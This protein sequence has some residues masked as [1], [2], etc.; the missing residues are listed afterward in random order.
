MKK[1]DNYVKILEIA[2]NMFSKLGYERTSISLIAEEMGF[3]KPALYN[4]FKSKEA[5]FEMLYGVII[6]EI[7]KS[8]VVLDKVND[9]EEYKIY[10]I[11]MGNKTIDDLMAKPEFSSMLMQFFLLGLRNETIAKLTKKLEKATKKHFEEIVSLGVRCGAVDISNKVLYVEMLLM[12]DQG[13][14]EKAP[15]MEEKLLKDVWKMFIIKMF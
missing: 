15:Y 13:I 5:I 10:L 12:M 9:S 11:N 3:S 14:L 1:K 6:D 7:I 8:Y 4:Y 2:Y